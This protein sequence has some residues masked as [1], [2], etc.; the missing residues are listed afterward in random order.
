MSRAECLAVETDSHSGAVLE[1]WKTDDR[2]HPLEVWLYA[3]DRSLVF[4][5]E[6]RQARRLSRFFVKEGAEQ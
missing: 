6:P 1:L 3:D 4:N 5:M 2:E